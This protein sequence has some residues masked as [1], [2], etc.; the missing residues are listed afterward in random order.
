MINE[1][2]NLSDSEAKSVLIEIMDVY[3]GKGFGLMNKTEIETL[4]YHVLK[5]HSILEGKCFPDS[6]KLK[7][8]EARARRLIYESQIKYGTDNRDERDMHLRKAVGDCLK[9][10]KFVKNNSEIRFA[11]E[12]KYTRDALNAKLRENYSFA[13]TSFNKD[14]ISLDEEAF[15]DLVLLLVPNELKDDVLKKITELAM[16]KK[17]N[18]SEVVNFIKDTIKD[19]FSGTI[20]DG[21]KTVGKALIAFAI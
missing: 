20:A 3:F 9:H 4:F 7:V 10:A 5:N 12:D 15:K 21:I 17:E 8:T 11:I 18:K 19:S 2:K 13:D 14:I 16:S 1:I 6:F